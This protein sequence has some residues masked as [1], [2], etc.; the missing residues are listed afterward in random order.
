VS[1]RAKQ[2]VVSLAAAAA[3]LASGAGPAR[4]QQITLDGSTGMLPLATE[5]VQ[6]FKA[7]HGATTVEVGKGSS[8]ASAM[9]AVAD[10]R[11]GIGLS[12][13]P[14]GEAER[15]AGLQGIEIA[16]TAVVLAVHASVTIPG[17]TSQ[18]VCDIYA[19]RIKNWKEVGGADLS[20]YPL[21][22][23]ADE[24]DPTIIK[25]HYACF[26]EAEGVLILPK[27]G[28]MAKALSS[29]AGAIGMINTTYVETSQGATRALVL[30]SVAPTP[31]NVQSEA[32]P[33]IRRFFFVTKG[34]PAGPVAQFVAFVK[35][36]DGERVIRSTKAVPVK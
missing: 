31:E 5:L 29:K 23:P 17:L 33:L 19:R 1:N 18:Q 16:R 15:A 10:G 22:R 8:S 32:Y 28:D 27:A 25:K 21:T 14:P 34:A 7:K 13:D 11:I 4:A 9:R 20:I 6:A 2:L 12:S 36:T 26:K 30:N 24:F 35:S 3:L